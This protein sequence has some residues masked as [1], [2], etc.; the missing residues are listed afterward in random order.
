MERC[1]PDESEWHK[2]Y[3]SEPVA[4]GARWF[5]VYVD[6]RRSS[7]NTGKH[8]WGHFQSRRHLIRFLPSFLPFFSFLT[9]FS[10]ATSCLTWNKANGH[11]SITEKRSRYLQMV[12]NWEIFVFV[13]K[14]TWYRD[15]F[16]RQNLS[17]LWPSDSRESA[18][19]G[20]HNLKLYIEAKHSWHLVTISNAT[21]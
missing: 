3:V 18:V 20:Q 8:M 15:I 16:S 5:K 7:P 9:Y 19:H 13:W 17:E 1:L 6:F 2:L 21:N 10:F 4:K 12:Q 14:Q 11:H